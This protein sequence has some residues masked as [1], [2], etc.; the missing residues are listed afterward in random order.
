MLLI[1]AA[2]FLIMALVSFTIAGIFKTYQFAVPGII[3]LAFLTL[4]VVGEGLDIP[5]SDLV[6]ATSPNSSSTTATI[7]AQ[8]TN[9]QSPI[10]SGGA[11]V[12]LFSS[13]FFTWTIAAARKING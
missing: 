2:I 10:I 8:Y 12:L 4:T 9:Y 13:V 5:T 1:L 11:V 7:E 3:F 6:I